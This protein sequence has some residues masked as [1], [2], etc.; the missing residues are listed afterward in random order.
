MNARGGHVNTG[1]QA[2]TPPGETDSQYTWDVFAPGSVRLSSTTIREPNVVG[3]D[4][5][6][7]V[8][9]GDVLSR[10]AYSTDEYGQVVG[11]VRFS[12][13]GGGWTSFTALEV[14]QT[15]QRATAYGLRSDG[16]LFR[17]NVTSSGWRSAGS[18]PGFGSVK[19]MALISKTSTYDTFLV[20]LRGGALY[21]VRIPTASPMKPVV[22]QVR[23][24]SWQGFEALVAGKCGQYGTLL[25]GIDKDTKQG[26]LYA[27]GHAN[28]TATVINSIGKVG[29]EAFPDPVY[30]RWGVV[31]E[32]DPLNGA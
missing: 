21:T 31:P 6:G 1:V 2:G 19:A 29:Y 32:L 11:A 15:A 26:Y 20:N 27:V 16:V 10:V 28:G 3:P 22:K 13:V 14:A 12:R 8:V 23:S 9:Q 7:W 4:V 5:A 25:L 17:W 24:R 30:F 18:A